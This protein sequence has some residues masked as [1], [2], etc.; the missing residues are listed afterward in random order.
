M[1]LSRLPAPTAVRALGAVFGTIHEGQ[2]QMGRGSVRPSMALWALFVVSLYGGSVLNWS[3]S[4]WVPTPT[5]RAPR[6][7]RRRRWPPPPPPSRSAAVARGR[8][9]G[10]TRVRGR[11]LG[12]ATATTGLRAWRG[13]PAAPAAA[14][15]PPRG[16]PTRGR[17]P[18]RGAADAPP[19]VPRGGDGAPSV[20]LRLRRAWRRADAGGGAGTLGWAP[21]TA[22]RGGRG[23]V[24]SFGAATAGPPARARSPHGRRGV[25]EAPRPGGPRPWGC[26]PGGGYPPT[27]AAAVSAA[28][29]AVQTGRGGRGDAGGVTARPVGGPADGHG[30][31]GPFFVA[32]ASATAAALTRGGRPPG[33]S[34]RRRRRPPAAAH[35]QRLG[36]P[37]GRRKRAAS[38][39]LPTRPWRAWGHPRRRRAAAAARRM[40]WRRRWR[41]RCVPAVG[42]RTRVAGAPT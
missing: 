19:P 13:R 22:T 33:R 16:R 23:G 8:G 24:G 17:A 29:A 5:G 15:R 37:R 25:G 11:A 18:D 7:R 20:R 39:L 21:A 26:P 34:P 12:V 35:E 4:H 27:G 1:F 14:G 10:V 6:G 38:A 2:P 41:R 3:A 28:G 32:P 36:A 42:A 9:G 30:G 40:F 31:G